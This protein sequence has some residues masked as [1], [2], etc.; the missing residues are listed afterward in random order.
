[1]HDVYTQFNEKIDEFK[2]SNTEENNAFDFV[3]KFLGFI[4]RFMLKAIIKFLIWLDYHGWL[5]KF[6]LNVSPFHGSLVITSMASLGIPPIY[7]HLYDFGNVPMFI[8][9]SAIRRQNEILN[10]GSVHKIRYLELNI[11]MDERI[12]D[13]HYYAAALHEIR[14]YL[15]NPELLEEPPTTIVHDI[16]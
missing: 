7:H 1:L 8:S 9:F 5:P 10:D 12:C 15:K 2:D 4:P 3:A 11:T 13:G 14:K 16:D 6:L